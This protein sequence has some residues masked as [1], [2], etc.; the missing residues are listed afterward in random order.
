MGETLDLSSQSK[1]KVLDLAF[2]HKPAAIKV[3]IDVTNP[4][5]PVSTLAVL[6]LSACPGSDNAP[7]TCQQSYNRPLCLLVPDSD[8]DTANPNVQPN[9]D[10][11]LDLANCNVYAAGKGVTPFTL[12]LV[13]VDGQGN[14]ISRVAARTVL[15]Q[16]Q[17]L[18]VRGYSD[19]VLPVSF[20]S[21]AMNGG[22]V[23]WAGISD[24][25]SHPIRFIPNWYIGPSSHY[26]LM[27]RTSGGSLFALTDDIP[28][29]ALLADPTW[30]INYGPA[31]SNSE[32]LK[33]AQS[34]WDGPKF[35]FEMHDQAPAFGTLSV[36]WSA[37]EIKTAVENI[38]FADQ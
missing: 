6:N 24:A 26:G 17:I 18:D 20:G 38:I 34:N 14:M 31:L 1:L 13:F 37:R 12:K 21:F 23:T 28:T 15:Q 29:E 36:P 22:S 30:M 2:G 8:K 3:A 25:Q 7:L 9:A 27:P 11:A 5:N 19:V 16:L 4:A 35:L 10:G 32:I 33:Q